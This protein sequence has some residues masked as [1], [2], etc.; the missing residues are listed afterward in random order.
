MFVRE[1]GHI[2]AVAN[3]MWKQHDHL[4][5]FKVLQSTEGNVRNLV[6][7]KAACHRLVGTVTG[8]VVKS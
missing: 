6:N 3:G 5:R 1:G 2:L 8:D 7:R 4:Q